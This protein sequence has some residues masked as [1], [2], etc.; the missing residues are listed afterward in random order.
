MGN[1]CLTEKGEGGQRKWG[2]KDFDKR[3]GGG[4]KSSFNIY[5]KTYWSLSPY[6]KLKR[7]V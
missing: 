3:L 6:R 1:H 5:L 2:Q 7:N 4:A